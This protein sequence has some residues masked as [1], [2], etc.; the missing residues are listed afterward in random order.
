MTAAKF[1]DP[2]LGLDIHM[3]IIPGP[4]GTAPL[5][6]PFVGAVFDPLGAAM[7]A[8]I[9]AV[10]GGGGPVFVNGMPTGNSGTDVMNIPHFPTPP[11]TGPAPPDAPPD[12]EGTILTGSKTVN[13]GG[14]SQAR[15]LSHVI[16]CSYPV[17]LPSSIVT[18]IP[19]GSPVNIGGPEA[20]DYMVA[21]TSAL[22][23]TFKHAK[24]KWGKSVSSWAHKKFNLPS[25]SKH[26]KFV[27]FLTCHPVDVASGELIAEAIDFEFGGAILPT[28]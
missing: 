20:I 19:G 1:G 3:V 7:G 23:G 27:C 18:P 28:Q 13:F 25:G 6:H 21:A 14:S 12:N 2:V 4:P 5:P 17:D 24:G 26:S 22:K 10:F 9:G 16:S 11:G 15:E 8:A